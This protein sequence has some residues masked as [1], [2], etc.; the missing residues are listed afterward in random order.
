MSPDYERRIENLEIKL[1][2]LSQDVSELKSNDKVT[3]LRFKQIESGIFD[4]KDSL[5]HIDD[6]FKQMSEDFVTK[7]EMSPYKRVFWLI[8]STVITGIVVA[9]MSSGVMDSGSAKK[10]VSHAIIRDF[11]KAEEFNHERIA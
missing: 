4:I 7:T 9:I 5:K 10:E 8:G 2:Q 6:N 3:E 1:D 11:K